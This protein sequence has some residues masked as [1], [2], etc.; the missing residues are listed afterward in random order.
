MSQY[1][2]QVYS[3]FIA[4]PPQFDSQVIIYMYLHLAPNYLI[5]RP[6]TLSHL[7]HKIQILCGDI[8]SEM[9]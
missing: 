7:P 1:Q 6:F 5:L 3:K 9:P 2:L 4:I 8:E